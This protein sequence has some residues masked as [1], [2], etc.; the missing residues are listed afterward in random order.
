VRQWFS[1]HAY[2]VIDWIHIL[3]LLYLSK[4]EGQGAD[5]LTKVIV[6]AP[7]LEAGLSREKIG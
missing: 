6:R 5:A 4:I 7:M 1:L 2:V 3:V